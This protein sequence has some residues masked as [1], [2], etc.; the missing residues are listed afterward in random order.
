MGM[1]QISER[2]LAYQRHKT[3]ACQPEIQ[4]KNLI[5]GGFVKVPAIKTTGAS[6][7]VLL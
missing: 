2:H 7:P 3:A 4:D 6:T 1:W 5:Q